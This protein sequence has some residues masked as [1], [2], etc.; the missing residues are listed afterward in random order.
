LRDT[1]QSTLALRHVADYAHARVNER[2]A[3][4]SLRWSRMLVEAVQVHGGRE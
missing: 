2:E 3:S 4:R 1:L